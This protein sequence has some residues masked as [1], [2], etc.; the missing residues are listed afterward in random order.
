MNTQINENHNKYTLITFDIDGTLLIGCN[1]GTV[2]RDSYK[3]AVYDVF[4]V[5]EEIPKYRQGTDLGTSKQIM[6]YTLKKQNKKNIINNQMIEKF[7]KS[8]EDHYIKLFDGKLNVMPGV[9][10]V[11]NY[12]SKLPN[13]K[14]IGRA[15]V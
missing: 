2:H 15:H 14:K 7:I 4:G 1:K 3:G 8:T 9:T 12:L 5:D 13:V 10:N 11:L 6:E